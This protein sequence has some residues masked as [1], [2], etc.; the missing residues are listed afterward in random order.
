MFEL[1]FDTYQNIAT[2]KIH[3]AFLVLKISTNFLTRQGISKAYQNVSSV[4][5]FF[6]LRRSTE[7]EERRKILQGGLDTEHGASSERGERDALR[8]F[9][10]YVHGEVNFFG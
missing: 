3:L 9:L 10:F 2:L 8:T 1:G 4:I 5:D 6:L 7:A